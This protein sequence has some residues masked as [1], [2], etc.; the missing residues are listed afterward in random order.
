MERREVQDRIY[1]A[2]EQSFSVIVGSA[3]AVPLARK[4]RASIAAQRR[5]DY[6]SDPAKMLKLTAM[7]VT[8]QMVKYFQKSTFPIRS[9][10]TLIGWPSFTSVSDVSRFSFRVFRS[11]SCL[12]ASNSPRN[13][14]Y[15]IVAAFLVIY[16]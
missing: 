4:F 7:Y 8:D 9:L 12:L 6:V 3:F 2:A 1:H 15:K 13:N 16:R 11:L 5:Y 14:T 10:G